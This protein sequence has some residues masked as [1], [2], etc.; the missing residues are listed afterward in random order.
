MDPTFIEDIWFLLDLL[1]K[2][3][4]F[5]FEGADCVFHFQIHFWV[6]PERVE[7]TSLFVSFGVVECGSALVVRDEESLVGGLVVFCEVGEFLA[8]GP[9]FVLAFFC[10]E[11]QVIG[12]FCGYECPIATRQ[13]IKTRHST[14]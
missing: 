14:G 3:E 1:F 9:F 10:G 11:F 4:S 5:P 7:C 6:I 8:F 2:G 12:P 13:L